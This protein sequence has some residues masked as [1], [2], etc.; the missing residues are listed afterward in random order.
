MLCF[1]RLSV[2]SLGPCTLEGEHLRLEPL[3]KTH[4]RGLLEAGKDLDWA[5]M[6]AKLTDGKAINSFISDSLKAES[7]GTEF[8]FAIMLKDEHNRVIGSTRYLDVQP[9]H[10]GVEI[11]WTWYSPEFWGTY[12][13]PETKFILLKHAFED[14][15]AIRVQ[16]KTDHRNMHSQR[17]IL[18]LGAK[19]EGRLRQHRIR[20]DRTY[21]DTMMYSILDIEWPTV[22]KTL[23]KRIMQGNTATFHEYD[24]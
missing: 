8:P 16:L 12:V 2:S 18:K 4:A 15:K 13:N 11:G 5:W 20:Y 14:W 6:P 24:Y 10:K 19:F 23:L 9:A 21:R 22:K 3:R 17:A 7:Q 1:D